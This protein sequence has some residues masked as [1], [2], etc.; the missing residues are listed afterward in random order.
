[1]IFYF[2]LLLL[3]AFVGAKM[4]PANEFM[5]D[6]MAPRNTRAVNGFFVAYVILRHSTQFVTFDGPYD[7]AFLGIYRFSAR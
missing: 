1:M 6:Y 5:Q 7:Q 4:A 2:L 3:V